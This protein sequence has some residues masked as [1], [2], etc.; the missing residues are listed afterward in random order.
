[1]YYAYMTSEE[2]RRFNVNY[3]ADKKGRGTLAK[4]MGYADTAYLN[5]LCGGHGSFGGRTARK[6]EKVLGLSEGDF[7]VIHEHQRDPEGNTTGK[8]P[9]LSYVQAGEWSEAIDPYEL[10]D[11]AEWAHV[12]PGHGESVFF[13]KVIGVSMEPEYFEG[14][15]ILVDFGLEARHGD[16]VVVRTPDGNVTFKRLQITPDGK[17][18]LAINPDYPQRIIQMPVGSVIC[19]VVV[20]YSVDKRRHKQ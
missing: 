19:G 11:A 14:G 5:Q 18:L 15:R 10:G 3:W 6:L 7:D 2:I 9:V 8:A 17:H 4:M 16:D 13:L 1:M 12:P 20:S